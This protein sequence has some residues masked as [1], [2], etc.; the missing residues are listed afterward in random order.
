MSL[1]GA[2]VAS[3]LVTLTRPAWWVIALAAFLVRGGVLVVLLPIVTLPTAAGLANDLAPTLVGFV[4]GGPSAQ[5][6]ILVGTILA[7]TLAWFIAGGLVGARLDLALV[8]EAADDEELEDAPT[9]RSGGAARAFAARTIAHAPT[10]VVLVL[11]AVRLVDAVYLELIRPGDPAIPALVRVAL[12]IPETV[13]LVVAVWILG[14]ALGG[15]AVR[16]LAWSSSLP[17]ALAGAARSLVRPSALATL[18]V[19]NGALAV[20]VIGAGLTAGIAWDHLRVVLG[21]GGTGAEVRLALLVFSVTWFAGLWLLSLAAAWRVTAWT[22]E[23][24]RH[25]PLPG[26]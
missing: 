2:L 6:L 16:H 15:L 13:G 25:L 10:G 19:T 18:I 4:F 20:A 11:G 23:V 1:A 12:R 5:F 7:A 21:D 22:F 3:F 17:R 24:A 14:E 26:D 8:Q 9:P